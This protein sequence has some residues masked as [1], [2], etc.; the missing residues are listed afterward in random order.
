[1]MP[2]GEIEVGSGGSSSA[3]S[4]FGKTSVALHDSVVWNH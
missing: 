2:G 3:S 1:M 4:S